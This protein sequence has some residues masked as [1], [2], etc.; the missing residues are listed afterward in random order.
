MGNDELI[1]FAGDGA[2]SELLVYMVGRSSDVTGMGKWVWFDRSVGALS[3][4]YDW[5]PA[6]MKEKLKRGKGEGDWFV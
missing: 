4:L 6:K 3:S 1:S 2:T 5:I